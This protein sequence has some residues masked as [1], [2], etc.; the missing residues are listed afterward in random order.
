M[1]AIVAAGNTYNPCLNTLR[2]RGY[3]LWVEQG[4]GRPSHAADT[5]PTVASVSMPGNRSHPSPPIPSRRWL[6]ACWLV[7]KGQ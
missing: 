4:D 6:D 1:E 7:S 3:E 2:R 5:V